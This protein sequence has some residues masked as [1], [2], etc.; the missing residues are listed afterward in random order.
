[1]GANPEAGVVFGLLGTLYG[2]TAEGGKQ[3]LDGT[4]F[5]L[6]PITRS[7]TTLHV[8]SGAEDGAQPRAGLIFRNGAL[9]GTTYAGGVLPG[10]GGGSGTVFQLNPAT[11]SLYTLHTFGHALPGGSTDGND[12]RGGLVFVGDA[13]Y[14]TTMNGGQHSAVGT[15]GTV[16]QLAH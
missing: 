5:R 16:F 9:F 2:T 8:F 3:P 15:A 13:F 4:V 1:G 14:G 7:F 12:P 10:G 11:Q 6:D